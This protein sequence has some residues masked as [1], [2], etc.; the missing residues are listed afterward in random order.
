MKSMV[1]KCLVVS[2]S[3]FS[4]S[5]VATAE[6]Y[7]CVTDLAVGFNY[8]KTTDTW[9]SSSAKDD[10]KYIIRKPTPDEQLNYKA[11]ENAPWVVAE[12][13]EDVAN[14]ACQKDFNKLGNLRCV[15]SGF[16]NLSKTVLSETF[17]AL[18]SETVLTEIMFSKLN[19]RFL[20][21]YMT[22]YW[23]VI[24]EQQLP[25]KLSEREQDFARYFAEGANTPSLSMGKCTRIE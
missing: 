19:L 21:S 16:S 24:S 13:G 15:E 6:S 25:T 4:I 23:N 7:L 17:L 10:R 11:F 18:F 22:G 12:F 14:W 20:H 2:L 9:E 5:H 1:M 3:V 8:E